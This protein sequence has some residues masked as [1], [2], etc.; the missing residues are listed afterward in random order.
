MAVQRRGR[1]FVGTSNIV[2]PAGGKESFPPEF[3]DKSRLNYYSSLFN[4]VEVNNTFK[5][6]P[7]ATTFEKWSLDVGDDFVFTVK[8]WREVTHVKKLKVDLDNIDLFMQAANHTSKKGCLLV[9][10]PASITAD[11]INEFEFILERLHKVDKKNEWR[12][13]IELRSDT[14]YN[15][16]TKTLLKKYKASLVLQDMPKSRNLEVNDKSPF[17]YFRFHGPKG[18]Y[19]GSYTDAFLLVQAAKIQRCLEKGKDVY[20]YFNNTMGNALNN[21]ITLRSMIES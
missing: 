12:K 15:N 9:Q 4:T 8:L 16:E 17:H 5:K 20:V 3:R 6:I 21:A 10:F 13:A 2:V 11:Y 1:L 7:Q 18:D 14:W 19:R